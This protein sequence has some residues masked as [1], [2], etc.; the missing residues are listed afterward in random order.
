[1]AA[2]AAA[3]SAAAAAAAAAPQDRREVARKK[4][5]KIGRFGRGRFGQFRTFLIVFQRFF[6]HFG[7]TTIRE[8]LLT[9][10]VRP[11]R[12]HCGQGV[13]NSDP[14]DLR[15]LSNALRLQSRC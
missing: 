9:Q 12:K 10:H 6:G 8:S 7:R 11:E 15:A 3:A 4:I 13:R 5:E 1:M 14:P 2:A